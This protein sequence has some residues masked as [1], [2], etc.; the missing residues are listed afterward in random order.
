MNVDEFFIVQFILNSLPSQYEPFQ[1]HYNIIKNKW[2]V[3]ELANMLI[4]EEA[5]L[6][7][8]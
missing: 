2:N 7:Q 5:R 8:Q 1:I 6:K 3:N 4:H